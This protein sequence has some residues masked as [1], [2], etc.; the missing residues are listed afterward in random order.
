MTLIYFLINI[1]YITALPVEKMKGIA[2]IGELASSS[3]FGSA[4]TFIISSAIMV[5]IFSCLSATILYGPRV[6]FA[7]AEDRSFFRGMAFVQPRYHVPTKAILGQAAWS[8]LLCL[9]GTYKDL[10]EFVVFALV[11]FFAA[12]GFAFIILRHKQPDIKR[13]YKTWG[14]P[15]IPLFF[16]L[17]NMAVFFNTIVAQSL[18]SAVGLIIL[19]IGIPDFLYWKV[20]AKDEKK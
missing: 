17:I 18:K 16:V 9:T 10:Y 1:V 5:S 2:R 12:T 8:S 7:M 15:W 3:L 4:A 20:K 11:I 13:P 14:Y 19:L 6:Y